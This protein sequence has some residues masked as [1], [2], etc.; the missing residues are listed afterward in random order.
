MHVRKLAPVLLAVVISLAAARAQ[1]ETA[2]SVTC[3]L[4]GH[5]FPVRLVVSRNEGGGRDSDGCRWALDRSSR[6]EVLELRE[7]VACPRCG[8]AFFRG[9]LERAARLG[10]RASEA[11]IASA[12]AAAGPLDP[13][14][15]ETVA[16]HVI[17]TY[18]ALGLEALGMKEDPDAF[19]GK[20][21]VRA[22]WA[23]R[24]RLVRD[25]ERSQA[26]PVVFAPR[27]A[28][29]AIWKLE[30]LDI[31]ANPDPDAPVE[32]PVEDAL[33]NLEQARSVLDPLD[34][35]EDEPSQR[36]AFERVRGALDLVEQT[37]LVLKAK[38]ETAR[39]ANAARRAARQNALAV[40]RAA[41][42][43]GEGARRDYWLV[44]AQ[45]GTPEQDISDEAM[46]LRTWVQQ[47]D[48]FLARAAAA[49]TKAGDRAQGARRAELLALAADVT[50]R[51]ISD[52]ESELVPVVRDLVRRALEGSGPGVQ[53]AEFLRGRVGE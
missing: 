43:A 37:L 12:L 24:M 41:H 3:P 9:H 10:R 5:T 25:E 11:P 14:R 44:I 50:R 22:A 21:W 49:L 1:D 33:S 2:P 28:Q 32:T 51:R 8:G 48:A 20:L 29:E 17:A 23:V 19:E 36:L 4:D 18:K 26:L 53:H 45:K 35:Q 15:L 39:Q 34:H 30:N 42:R 46:R 27:S 38:Y 40:A 52:A 6:L 47:E 7:L 13:Q 16:A 31:Q